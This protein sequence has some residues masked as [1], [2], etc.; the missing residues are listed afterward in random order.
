MIPYGK[1][2]IGAEDIAAITEVLNSDWLTTGPKVVEFEQAVADFCGVEHGVAMSNGTAALHAAMASLEIAPGDE[3]IVPAITFVATANAVVYQGGT[4]VFA[5]VDPDTLLV[6]PSSIKERLSPRTKLI[7]AMDYAGQPCE[8]D[9]LREI[10]SARGIPLLADACHAIG[11]EYK[12]TKVGA[13]ADV[14]TLSFH[15]VKPITTGEGGMV[16]TSDDKLAEKMRVFRNHGITTDF[17]QRESAGAWD[18]DMVSL[19]YNFRLPDLA[20]ALGISQL[21]K[22]PA[23]IARRNEI[24]EIYRKAFD[25]MPG[26]EPIPMRANRSHGYHLFVVKVA[27]DRT[28]AFRKLR[29]EGIGV[30]VHYKP[31]Y[32]H[33]FYQARGYQAGLCPIAEREFQKL[34]SLPIYPLMSQED[35]EEVVEQ[36]RAVVAA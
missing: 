14:T 16:L 33:P 5:D 12:G 25:S 3:V 31:V 30:S 8:Y 17:R 35:V 20:C 27:G 10:S 19:G 34:L 23:W 7:V 4:P 26:V 6:D 13:L 22:L 18:Y 15:P 32:L 21:K 11:A 36:L 28:A 24:A 2:T 29:A 1:Q 9:A